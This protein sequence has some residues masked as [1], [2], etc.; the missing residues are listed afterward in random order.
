MDRHC[1]EHVLDRFISSFEGGFDI[2]IS[3]MGPHFWSYFWVISR[4]ISY[5]V[6]ALDSFKN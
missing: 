6:S 4:H 3:E 5:M 1:S 2:T